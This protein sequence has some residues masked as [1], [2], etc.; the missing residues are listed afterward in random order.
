MNTRHSPTQLSDLNTN[1]ATSLEAAKQRLDH[2][3]TVH[4]SPS[5]SS[6]EYQAWAKTRLARQMTDHL[7]RRGYLDSA[8]ALARAEHIEPLV[9]AHLFEDCARIEASLRK[10]RVAEALAWCKENQSTL[11]K[12][13]VGAP[14]SC[15]FSPKQPT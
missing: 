13:K 6:P 12:M 10:G 9:D 1:N 4:A 11:K 2:L 15:F 8:K 5:L 14:L 3:Q 7:L